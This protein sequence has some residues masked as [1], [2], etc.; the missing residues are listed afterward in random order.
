MD[1]A[2]NFYIKF[3]EM[4]FSSFRFSKPDCNDIIIAAAMAN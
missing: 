3:N 2:E 1:S 4:F